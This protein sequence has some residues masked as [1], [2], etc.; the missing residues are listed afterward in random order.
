MK[1]YF[2][3]AAAGMILFAACRGSHTENSGD[4]DLKSLETNKEIS[5]NTN[6]GFNSNS[7]SVREKKESSS[8][9]SV[10]AFTSTASGTYS[11]HDKNSSPADQTKLQ[12]NIKIPTKIIKTANLRF[13]VEDYKK[14]RAAIDRLVHL[15][16]SYVGDEQ[17]QNN[18]YSLTN[19]MVLRVV[20]KDFDNMVNGLSGIAKEM[21]EKNISAA[22]V[23]GEYVDTYVRI[24]T[25]KEVL[26]Q[27][28]ELLHKAGSIQDILD[29][30][31]KIR[32]IQEELEA[33]EGSLKL[34]DD[35]VG[36]ST[37]NLTFYQTILTPPNETPGYF[38][39]LSVSFAKGWEGL[40]D[41]SV[42]FISA[43]PVWI[44]LSV[45]GFFFYRL[46]RKTLKNTKPA[47]EKAE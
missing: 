28:T 27:Y 46:I 3:I 7:S 40:L 36:Y 10:T 19:T 2:F 41:F 33:K 42:G 9:D 32:E 29:V 11:F 12:A 44:I 8:T 22:D 38:S 45:I 35:Q 47:T 23:T 21:N 39:K 30:E 26:K 20:S 15:Y 17:E 24:N 6:A 14:S 18:S 34:M 25:K 1:H 31:D 5:I 13:S 37:I 16:N 4:S 43:W